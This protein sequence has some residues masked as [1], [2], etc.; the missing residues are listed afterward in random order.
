MLSSI[1]ESASFGENKRSV[2]QKNSTEF[3]Y[4]DN[5]KQELFDTGLHANHLDR[6][7]RSVVI[8]ESQP[9]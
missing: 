1:N 2:D 8:N 3:V 6:N 9:L 4:N 7:Q 5:T